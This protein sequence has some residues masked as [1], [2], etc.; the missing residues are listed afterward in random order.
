MRIIIVNVS[1]YSQRKLVNRMKEYILP[2][3][4]VVLLKVGAFGQP[5][6][7]AS[8]ATTDRGTERWLGPK[9]GI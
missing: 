9:A 1:L 2:F 6:A 7:L 4:K 3:S 8:I 5:H